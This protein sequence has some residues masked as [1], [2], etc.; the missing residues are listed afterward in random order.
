MTYRLAAVL[1]TNVQRGQGRIET[2]PRRG[3]YR[4]GVYLAGRHIHCAE[5]SLTE[6]EAARYHLVA[7]DLAQVSSHWDVGRGIRRRGRGYVAVV[8]PQHHFGS[9]G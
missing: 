7:K 1:L 5:T 8:S 9:G 3:T 2:T 6:G 4:E